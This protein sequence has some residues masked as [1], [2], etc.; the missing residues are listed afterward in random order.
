MKDKTTAKLTEFV[1]DTRLSS[2]PAAALRA[3]KRSVFNWCGLVL[4]A[5]GHPAV[6][7][8]RDWVGTLGGS[9]ATAVGGVRTDATWAALVN[10][11]A[12]HVEDFDDTHYQTIIHPTGPVWSAVLAVAEG[13]HLS[14]R[15]ALEAFILGVDVECRVGEAVFPS[16]YNRGYHIT[17][18]AGAFGATAA[19]GKLLDLSPTQFQEALGL[20]STMA[21]GL[22]GT[23]G[24]MAKPLHPGKAAMEGIVAAQLARRGFTS[25]DTGLESPLGFCGV[26]ADDYDLSKITDRLGQR[27]LVEENAIKPFACG[28]VAHAAMDGM[29]RHR[30]RGVRP[31]DVRGIHLRVHPRVRQLT[32]NPRPEIGLEG[33][34]SVQHG[35]AVS[36]LDGRAGPRQYT[37]ERVQADEVRSLRDRVSIQ[38]DS[39]LRLD[40]AYVTV[41]LHGGEERAIHVAH[42]VSSLAN[43]M[44][45]D[46]L[47]DKV[48]DLLHDLPEDRFNSLK[49][50]VFSLPKLDDVH[51]ITCYLRRTETSTNPRSRTFPS[52]PCS[53]A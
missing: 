20:V 37:D 6:R 44:P 40:E 17:A 12:S 9:G 53:A 34:F 35:V 48:R 27:W 43:P 28:V 46:M 29:L 51:T 10:G 32:A 3:A 50:D 1:L 26:L 36:L 38:V 16:H 25:G 11:L 39:A 45:D 33:K 52:R 15:Q 14:G 7:I 18:T 22:R 5:R 30:R 24:S 31:H 19:V 49:D 21:S 8:A 47:D 2:I 42:A 23:F 4:Q 13:A 41:T